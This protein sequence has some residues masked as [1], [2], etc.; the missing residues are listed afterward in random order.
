[1]AR[2]G[3]KR[4]GRAP[5]RARGARRMAAQHERPSRPGQELRRQSTAPAALDRSL[6]GETNKIDNR[7]PA[8]A[9]QQ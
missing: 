4:G 5:C 8:A 3:S 9:I 6:L 2:A 7:G 1:M